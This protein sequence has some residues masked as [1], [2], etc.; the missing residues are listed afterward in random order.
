MGNVNDPVGGNT[1]C[2]G[3]GKT[4][5]RRQRLQFLEAELVGNHC[6]YCQH[7]IAGIF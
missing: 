2:P 5:I 1:V 4:V 3:C 6:K 7:E